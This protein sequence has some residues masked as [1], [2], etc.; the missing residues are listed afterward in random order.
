ESLT[1]VLADCDLV[2]ADLKLM[3]CDEHKRYTG[4]GNETILRNLKA[5]DRPLIVRTPVIGGVNDTDD[6]IAAIAEFAGKL[7]L[8]LYYEL[9]PYHPLGLSKGQFKQERFITPSSERMSELA[10]VAGRYCRNVRIAGRI[11]V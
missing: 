11:A 3:N 1:S 6:E 10:M 8:L 7:P 2:M 9:L 5:V 4:A